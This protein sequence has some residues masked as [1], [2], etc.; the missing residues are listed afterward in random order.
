MAI[1]VRIDGH[2]AALRGKLPGNLLG[3]GDT[4][5]YYQALVGTAHSAGAAACQNQA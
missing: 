1:A 2:A 3:Y 4:S 5:E